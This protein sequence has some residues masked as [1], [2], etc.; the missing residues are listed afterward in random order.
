MLDAECWMLDVMTIRF[1][2]NKNVNYGVFFGEGQEWDLCALYLLGSNMNS[3]LNRRWDDCC[4]RLLHT[5]LPVLVCITITIT[6][7]G[8]GFMLSFYR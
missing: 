4:L 8:R 2:K 1:L 6:S 3:F 7:L 5:V